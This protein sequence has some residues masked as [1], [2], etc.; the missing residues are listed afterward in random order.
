MKRKYLI[1]LNQVRS[2]R[3]PCNIL[4]LNP[5]LYYI[6]AE[7]IDV[8]PCHFNSILTEFCNQLASGVF[9]ILKALF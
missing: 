2:S 1:I 3:N 8:T 4:V 9:K 7:G 5:V 6:R